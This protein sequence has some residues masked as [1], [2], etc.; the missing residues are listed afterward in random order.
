MVNVFNKNQSISFNTVHQNNLNRFNIQFREDIHQAENVLIN[1]KA[2]ESEL[3]IKKSEH[4]ETVYTPEGHVLRRVER[5]EGE[6]TSSDS[7]K[8]KPDTTIAFSLNK[9]PQFMDAVI[10]SPLQTLEEQYMPENYI[11]PRSLT[12]T[13]LIGKEKRYKGIAI[14]AEKKP[15]ETEENN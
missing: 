1:D 7:F 10:S 15:E 2:G 3:I 5:N 12:L 14:P 11:V 8:F 13:T 9:D 6:T 4:S